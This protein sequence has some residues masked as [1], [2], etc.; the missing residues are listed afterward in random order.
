MNK[1]PFRMEYKGYT[2]ERNIRGMYY[3]FLFHEGYYF[4]SDTIG[5]VKFAISRDI[6]K[7]NMF[8]NHSK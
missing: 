7:F 5:A 4:Q 3:T 2:I 1:K 8:T 6:E